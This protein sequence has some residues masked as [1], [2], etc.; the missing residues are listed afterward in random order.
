MSMTAGP[1]TWGAKAEAGGV[2]NFQGNSNSLGTALWATGTNSVLSFA[3][4][5]NAAGSHVLLQS[6]GQLDLSATTLSAFDIGSLA[7]DGTASVKLGSNTLQ[8]GNNNG[9]SDGSLQNNANYAGKFTGP[10]NLIKSGN[11]TQILS[12]TGNTVNEVDVTGGTLQ[13]K[14]TGNFSTTGAYTTTADGTTDIGIN[15]STLKIGGAF[16]QQNGA[17][18]NVALSAINNSPAIITADSAQIGG[19]LNIAGFSTT[20]ALDPA[21]MQKASTVG[22]NEYHVISTASGITG[23]FATLTGLSAV[24]VADYL[25]VDGHQTA[26]GKGYDVGLELAWTAVDP[27]NRTGSFTMAAG[28][29]FNVDIALGDETVAG[30]APNAGWDGKSLTKAGDGTLLLSAQ[31]TY[32]GQTAVNGGLLRTGINNAFATSSDI[33]VN[34]GGILDLNGYNQLANRVQGAGSITLNGAALTANNQAAGTDDTTFGGIISDG[35]VTGGGLIKKGAGQLTLT[36]E[37]SFTGLT[38]IT[39]G[40]LQIGDGGTSG[41]IAGDIANQA[42][43]VFDR[44]DDVVYAGQLSGTGS[45]TKLG[46]GNLSLTQTGTQGGVTVQSGTLNF[47][48]S[49]AF[50]VTG[51][52][53]TQTGA[54]TQIGLESSQ[55]TVAGDFTQEAGSTLNV[56]LGA[57]PDI[58]ART[59][60]LDGDLVVNGFSSVPPVRAS[61]VAANVYTLISTTG[62]PG[63]IT[64]DFAQT[65]VPGT[66]LDYLLQSGSIDN[67][68]QDYNLRFKLAWTEGGRSQGTGSFTLNEGTSFNVDIVL[69]NQDVPDDG[70][71][72]T[73]WNGRDLTK[74]GDGLLILSAQNTYTGATMVNGGILQTDAVDAIASS[75]AVTVNGTLD[76]NNNNQTLQHLSGA[77]TGQIAMGTADLTAFNDA[78]RDTSYAGSIAGDGQLI[79]TGGGELTLSGATAWNGQTQIQGGTL[80]L[81]GSAGGG[82]LV[83]D[84]Y[85]QDNTALKLINGAT[86]TGKI[87]PTDVT[88]DAASTWNMTANSQVNN[89]ALNGMLN[90][91][92]PAAESGYKTLTVG[93]TLGGNGSLSMNTNLGALQGDLVVAQATEGQ[94]NVYINNQGSDPSGP[95]QSLKIIDVSAPALSNGTFVLPSGQVDAGAYRYSLLPGE[96]VAGGEAGDWYLA[97][98]MENSNLTNDVLDAANAAKYATFASLNSLHK[99]LGELRLD[100]GIEGDLWTRGYSKDYTMNLGSQIDQT[101]NGFEVG[102]DH[103]IRFNG[104]RFYTGGL[105]GAGQAN[106]SSN[107][108]DSGESTNQQVGAYGTWIFDNGSYVDLIGRYFWF[109]R[110]YRT[111]QLGATEY[112]TGNSQNNALSLDAEAGKR[113]D[114]KQGWFVEPQTELNWLRS[115]QSN[116]TTSQ[117][118]QIGIDSSQTINGRLGLAGGKVLQSDTGRLT[119]V[120]GQLDWTKDLSSNG[121]VSING[122]SF[123]MV[124][125]DGAWIAT[126]GVQTA[127]GE[128]NRLQFHVEVEAGLGDPNVKQNWGVNAGLRWAF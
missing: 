60:H 118:N 98:T 86:L 29:A 82:Q 90:F 21:A 112:D 74:N 11:L 1:N 84:V 43:L 5:A 39:G 114:F 14:Q 62:G 65:N 109:K 124:K 79:K 108:N 26:D 35:A 25:L 47:A 50:S 48:Q 37:N 83:S 72:A 107:T 49:G 40:T 18:L 93:G 75:D 15:G 16:T 31:N 117:G 127:G 33:I 104:G 87:D 27:A 121:R 63:S 42:A 23:D 99:R 78:G 111:W 51:N 61:E 94:H 22:A 119:Q 54:A 12:G 46:S 123:E 17:N 103:L 55:L 45:L 85:G 57:S 81:D 64:G 68:A 52:Y 7:G 56:T 116:F 69:E 128:Q 100:Q 38:A 120:Y 91:V 30:A 24:T 73:G 89:L 102:V 6:A 20:D 28:T 34:S 58:I 80:T 44:S 19:T 97:N 32:T 110:D 71:F 3:N 88:V 126:L 96:Q 105:I 67:N 113:F 66:N 10:G 125:D 8:I 115:S 70:G 2:V 106:T 101:V 122:N 95:G 4:M 13:F 41:S 9:N 92:P 77:A 59:A 76:M 53:L 36:G